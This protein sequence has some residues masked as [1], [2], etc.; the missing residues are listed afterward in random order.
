[1]PADHPCLKGHFPGDP[2]VPGVA[3]VVAVA[4]A[5]ARA[6]WP[7]L[8]PAVGLRRLKFKRAL[9][10]ADELVLRLLRSGERVAF[11]IRRGDEEATRGTLLFATPPG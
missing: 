11:R 7:D 8:G 1:M 9:R 6:A 5:R 10:P 4:E 3:Q 2:M